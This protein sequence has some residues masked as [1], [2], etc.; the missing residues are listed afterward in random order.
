MKGSIGLSHWEYLEPMWE[1]LIDKIDIGYA[2]HFAKRMENYKTNPQLGYR[3]AGSDAEFKTGELIARE[4]E[5]IGLT[6]FKDAFTLD[7]WEFKKAKLQYYSPAGDEISAEL[8]GYQTQFNTHGPQKFTIINAG[9]GT[10]EEL[11]GLDL[12]GKLALITINQRDEW[13]INYP[14]YQ[15]HL[16]G[17]AAV[18]AMQSQGYGEVNARALNAQDICGPADAPAFSISKSDTQRLIKTLGLSFGQT[19]EVWLDASSN[20]LPGTTSYN[21]SGSLKGQEQDSMILLTAHYDSYFKGFQD[22]NTA[23][24]LMLGIAKAMVESGYQPQKTIVF[25]AMA[26]EEWGVCNTRYDWSTGAYN[27]IFR[28]HPEWVGKLFANINFELPARSHGKKHLIRCVYEYKPFIK[29]FLKCFPAQYAQI[30]PNGIGVVSP[31][32]TWS[33]DFSMAIA[34]VPSMVNEFSSGSFMETHYHTQYDSDT[35]YDEAAYLFHHQLYSRLLLFLDHLVLPPVHFLPR[36]EALDET[37]IDQALCPQVEGNFRV[38][39]QQAEK[40]AR[41]LYKEIEKRNAKYRSL[42][43][44]APEKAINL[45]KQQQSCRYELIKIFRFC[46]DHFVKLNWHDESLLPHE[47]M[48]NNMKQLR[49]ACWQMAVKRPE[50]ALE[51]LCWVDNNI[52]AEAFDREVFTYFTNYALFQPADRLTWGTGRLQ[53]HLDLFDCIH[54]IKNKMKHGNADYSTNICYL[55]NCINE[56]HKQLEKTVKEETENLIELDHLMQQVLIHYF[57]NPSGRQ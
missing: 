49:N 13:W 46:E 53:G 9:R 16:H 30:Y 45:A 54:E 24:G 11:T 21:I 32:Q 3:T 38:A 52:Y 42:L 57:N 39:T 27:Q 37:L 15:A 48:Q 36:L 1:K 31:V 28:V 6:V 12:T 22:D 51:S 14:T 34:G 25:C 33:D 23:V 20:I 7:G 35:A 8:G 4:M 18:L 44:S 26:A 2:F 43:A 55:Q 10:A 56:Q 5:R 17:A 41:I 19:A 29:D 50:D 40:T 47:N